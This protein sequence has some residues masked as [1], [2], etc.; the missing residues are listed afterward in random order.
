MMCLNFWSCG[1]QR[2]LVE[3]MPQCYHHIFI[4]TI[5]KCFLRKKSF[6]SKLTCTIQTFWY[7]FGDLMNIS[8]WNCQVFYRWKTESIASTLV[9][10]SFILAG[11]SLHFDYHQ[12]NCTMPMLFFKMKSQQPSDYKLHCKKIAL[13]D[14][15]DS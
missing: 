12:Y 14:D 3:T 5:R 1:L 8:K 10:M 7:K 6:C 2:A 13:A 4:A 15:C 9:Y 11:R